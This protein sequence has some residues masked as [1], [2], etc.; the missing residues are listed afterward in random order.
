MAPSEVGLPLR[1][2]L[3]A[4]ARLAYNR[5]GPDQ[6]PGARVGGFAEREVQAEILKNAVPVYLGYVRRVGQA[7][8]YAQRIG[9]TAGDCSRIVV[10]SLHYNTG[11]V[12][13]G[14]TLQSEEELAMQDA[15]GGGG[16]DESVGGYNYGGANQGGGTI[17]ASVGLTGQDYVNMLNTA[18]AGTVLNAAVVAA[19]GSLSGLRDPTAVQAAL[20][21]MKVAGIAMGIINAI[22]QFANGLGG[23]GGNN[24]SQHEPGAQR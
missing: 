12:A 7:V 1:L 8:L 14:V 13:D 18:L 5:G 6:V 22:Q 3:P 17:P 23:G 21:A 20:D 19:L 15:G 2:R 9:V 16:T 10:A 24:S 4:A 11:H